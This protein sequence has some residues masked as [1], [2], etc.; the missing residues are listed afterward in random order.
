MKHIFAVSTLCVLSGCAGPHLTQAP[1]PQRSSTSLP[2]AMRSKP[3]ECMICDA[4]MRRRLAS[5]GSSSGSC[6][7]TCSG[8]DPVRTA[9]CQSNCQGMYASCAQSAS[10]PNDCPAYCAL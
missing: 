7:S 4:D 2:A 6:M 10:I 1:Q 8:G 3:P 9:L 5:C